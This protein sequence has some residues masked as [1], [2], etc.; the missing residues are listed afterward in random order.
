MALLTA[1]TTKYLTPL[2]KSSYVEGGQML[3]IDKIVISISK[4]E[5][6]TGEH[7]YQSS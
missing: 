7:G 4:I 3:L 6:Q 2:L 5:T 1:P